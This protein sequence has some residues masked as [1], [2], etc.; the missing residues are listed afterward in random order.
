MLKIFLHEKYIWGIVIDVITKV[1][2]D[3]LVNYIV[4]QMREKVIVIKLSFGSII[5]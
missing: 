2:D 4:L 1:L 5:M 3:K